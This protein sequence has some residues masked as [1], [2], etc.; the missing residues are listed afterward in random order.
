VKSPVFAVKWG[1]EHLANL[2]LTG[3][4]DAEDIGDLTLK[5]VTK[6]DLLL[7]ILSASLSAA[8]YRRSGGPFP[9][10]DDEPISLAWGK[11]SYEDVLYLLKAHFFDP[12]DFES[13]GEVFPPMV[14]A[15]IEGIMLL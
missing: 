13:V 6:N 10:T 7:K 12:W 4:V 5:P 3:V 8:S 1:D 2:I 9:L 11:A 14:E 15:E